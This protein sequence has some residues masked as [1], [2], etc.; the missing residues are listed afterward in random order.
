[1]SLDFTSRD[2]HLAYVDLGIHVDSW[3]A[4]EPNIMGLPSSLSS[5]KL[6]AMLLSPPRTLRCRL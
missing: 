3:V 2:F 6:R 4:V 5:G 1:M